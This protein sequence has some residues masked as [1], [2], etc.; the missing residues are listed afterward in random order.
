MTATSGPGLSLMTE[1]SGYAGM[2]E[3]PCVI[4]DAQRGGPSTGLPTKT[5]QSDLQHALYGGHGEAPRIVIAPTTVEDC[6]WTTIDAF[7]YAER[8]QVPVILLT[9]QCLATRM[10]VIHKPD[11]S[12][13]ELWERLHRGRP[14]RRLRALRA[15]RGRRL[16]DGHPRRGGR[17]VRGHRHRARRGSA[18][19]ATTPENSRGDDGPSGSASSSR[20][21]NGGARSRD[22]RRPSGR[23]SASSAGA[24]PT[25]RRARRSIC[26]RRGPAGQRLLPARARR[27]FPVD[28]D[29]ALGRGQSRV[30]V[31]EVNYT[32]QFARLVRARRAAS[33]SSQHAKCD[34]PAVHRRADRWT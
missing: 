28:A 9:D 6:F 34:G 29:R 20:S 14:Q 19:R 27:R 2:A 3:I 1:C 33:P 25:A 22:R 30:V 17:P 7:N 10:E 32:G 21:T 5:E 13:V 8:Y 16:A 11:L 26:P 4:V 18:T 31:P 23:T 24:R 12:R 15:H